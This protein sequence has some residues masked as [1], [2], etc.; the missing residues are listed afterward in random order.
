M[1]STLINYINI[2]FF[3]N[4]CTRSDNINN[5]QKKMTLMIKKSRFT[6]KIVKKIAYQILG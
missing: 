1:V 4:Y 6:A 3:I 5:D 2:T